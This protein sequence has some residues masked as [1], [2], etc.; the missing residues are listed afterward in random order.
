M[1]SNDSKTETII[2]I[3]KL[4]F[5]FRSTLQTRALTINSHKSFIRVIEVPSTRES[6]M[7]TNEDFVR[8][9]STS[10]KI[11]YS[12]LRLQELNAELKALEEERD[13]IQ[14]T[15]S[16]ELCQKV[17]C[18]GKYFNIMPNYILVLT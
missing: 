4:L 18:S 12:T 7:A 1:Y 3:L 16:A 5:Y 9:D 10:G 17:L 2:L 11:R 8:V 15:L 13:R 6:Q 14:K